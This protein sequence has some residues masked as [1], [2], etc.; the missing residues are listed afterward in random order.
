MLPEYA[1]T[2]LVNPARAGMIPWDTARVKA[3]GRK[4]RASGDDP[5]DLMVIAELQE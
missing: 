4:P 5:I 3:A 1:C 2:I